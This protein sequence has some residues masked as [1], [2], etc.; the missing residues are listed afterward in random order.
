[1]KQSTRIWIG[2]ASLAGIVLLVLGVDFVQRRLAVSPEIHNA[3]LPVVTLSPGSI[4]VRL[5]GRL[6]AG[7]SPDDL[8]GL[9]KVSFVEPLE[10]KTQEGWLLRDVLLKTLPNVGLQPESKVVVT[11]SSREKSA[12]LSWAEINDPANMVMFDLSNRGTLKLASKLEK[13]DTREEWVQ[14]VDQIEVVQ[15]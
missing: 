6:V 13:L 8:Q 1:V 9:E 10:G 11:S 7:F 5:D 14:D 4:P 15:P 2:L 12:E 3:D